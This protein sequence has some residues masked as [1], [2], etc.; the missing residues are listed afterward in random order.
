MPELMALLHDD[1]ST[2]G[3]YRLE[4]R[5]GTGGQGAVYAG[6]GP[7]GVLVAVKLLHPHLIADNEARVRFL[8]E[9]G[10]A[11]R[12]APF[13]TAQMLDSGF[14]GARPYIVSEFVDGPSLQ[15]S[16]RDGGPRGAAALQ[17]LAVNTAT[18][19]A[20][21][22]AAGVVHRDFKPGNVLLG[23]DGPVVID[24]G[25]ARALDLSQSVVTSQPIGSPAYMAPEQIAGGE[26]GPAVDLFA[27]AATMAYAA[28]GR[29][30]FG[31]DTIPATLHAVLR[32]EPDLGQLEGRF[33][34][35]LQECLSK[36]PARRPTAAQVVE[37][38]RVLPA[39]AW[40]AGPARRPVSRRV[41]AGVSVAA[42]LLTTAGV[43]LYALS[44]ATAQQQAA[45]G[46]TPTASVSAPASSPMI[47]NTPTPSVT[48]S[49][50]SATAAPGKK[51]NPV[52]SPAA[53]QTRAPR[54]TTTSTRDPDPAPSR[55]PTTVSKTMA[56]STPKPKPTYKSTPK[57]PSG[58][59]PTGRPAPA[60]STGTVSW[61]DGH[62][63]CKEQGYTMASG[64][65]MD[66]RCFQSDLV[67][68]PTLLCRWKYP[69]YANAV[70]EQPANGFTPEATCRLS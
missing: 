9:V 25:I 29:R 23:P 27:W 5:L 46:P 61:N 57:P 18:A 4:G 21:I 52:Q 47:S 48:K 10:T 65:W 30:A 26:I 54:K 7:N 63:Y 15:E 49:K 1:P 50:Q 51:A 6:R 20:A 58:E 45:A 43:G 38:L 40:Q 67:L 11:K 19:L 37:R 34:R 13:C 2:A 44:P 66:M 60:P 64:N 39:P 41:L 56:G 70:G 36:D 69:A 12:V 17:R 33:R 32:N 8:R 3:P 35:L 14:A 53:P 28:T 22:H 62:A 68:N 31:G 24:F 59:E 16:V 55:K 42:A